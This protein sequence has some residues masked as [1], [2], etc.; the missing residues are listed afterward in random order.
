MAKKK[1]TVD[2]HPTKKIVIKSAEVDVKMIPL[3]EWM[4]KIG[5]VTTLFCCQGCDKKKN[6]PYVLWTCFYGIDLV[7]VLED[8]SYSCKTEVAWN[9]Y[10]NQIEYYTHF[11][12]EKRFAQFMEIFQKRR[13]NE[14]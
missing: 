11:E 13:E 6:P 8:F 14:A 2:T 9:Q 5:S 4:N 7:R 12:N 1:A 10:K 3:I